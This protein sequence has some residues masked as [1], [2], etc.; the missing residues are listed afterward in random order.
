MPRKIVLVVAATALVVAAVAVVSSCQRISC[1]DIRFT[2]DVQREQA[3]DIVRCHSLRRQTPEAVTER[4]GAPVGKA[5]QGHGHIW[6]YD[7]GPGDVTIP[8]HLY[9]QFDRDKRVVAVTISDSC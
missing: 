6:D 9:V 2:G 5:S 7:L 3:G 8:C 1:D 4:L